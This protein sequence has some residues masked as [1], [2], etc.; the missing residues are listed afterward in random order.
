MG[1]EECTSALHKVH[2]QR[3]RECAGTSSLDEYVS[4]DTVIYDKS[5][6]ALELPGAARMVIAISVETPA[7]RVGAAHARQ[8]QL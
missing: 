6:A 5:T 7:G 1:D 4:T 3:A 2:S 8:R